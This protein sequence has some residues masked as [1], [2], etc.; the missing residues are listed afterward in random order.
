MTVVNIEI[1]D[2]AG[3]VLNRIA[4]EESDAPQ[5]VPEGGSFAV[6]GAASAAMDGLR[7][8]RDRR[9]AASDR[10]VLPDYPQSDEARVAWLAYRQALRDLPEATADPAQ[11]VWP[12]GPG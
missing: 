11:L 4:V 6:L 7:A 2:A 12:A 1:R 9:L 10:Y 3:T 8:E 5:F